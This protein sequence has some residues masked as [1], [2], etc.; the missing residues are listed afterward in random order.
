MLATIWILSGLILFGTYNSL[1]ILEGK[2]PIKTMKD[3]LSRILNFVGV[4]LLAFF[5]ITTCGL[6]GVKYLPMIFSSYWL[7]YFGI[8]NVIGEQK[9]FFYSTK[10]DNPKVLG[11][12][13]VLLF[14]SSLL[15]AYFI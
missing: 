2:L 5:C 13:K 7:L 6:F 14:I 4:M 12:M 3:I 8:R 9:P 15:F 11:L 1:M 10:F